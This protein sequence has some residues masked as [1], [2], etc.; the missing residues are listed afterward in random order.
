M[1]KTIKQKI[2]LVIFWIAVAT[3]L[4]WHVFA[5]VIA[6]PFYRNLTIEELSQTSWAI[7]GL[8]S[9]LS[10]FAIPLGGIL[11]GIGILLYSGAKASTT[12]KFGIGI[13][14][15]FIISLVT[16]ALGHFPLFFGIGGTLILLSF[17]GILWFWAKERMVLK[18]S[19]IAAADLRL[20]G[21][22]FMLIAAWF[23]CGVTSFPFMRVYEGQPVTSPIH[24]MI[25]LAL[26]WIFL[27]LSHYKSRRQ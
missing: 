3:V 6:A 9:L 5:W 14:L 18:G 19:S 20:V 15:V 24:V 25:L 2:G 27:F 22:V 16:I 26:G 8:G 23:I 13:V 4:L 10:M 17:F 7:G 1:T 12:G 11:A 21:Y